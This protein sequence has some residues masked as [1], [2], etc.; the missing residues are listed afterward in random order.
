MKKNIILLFFVQASNYLFPLLTLPY[1]MRVLGAENFGIVAMVQAWLQYI[2]IFVDYG[3]NFSATLLVSVNKN[4][5][6]KI[7]SIYTAV[8]AAKL[9]LLLIVSCIFALYV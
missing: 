6:S 7:D 5:Q 2:I 3:F 1:L 4:N 8:T 9:A